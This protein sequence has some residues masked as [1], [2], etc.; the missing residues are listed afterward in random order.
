MRLRPRRIP[1]GYQEWRRLLF[2]HWPVAPEV[3]RPLVPARLSLDLYDGI[4]YISLIPFWIQA[5]RPIGAPRALG[6]SFL[7]TNA[8]TYVHRDGREPGVYFFSLDS[9]SLASVVG[10]RLSVGLP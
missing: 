4:A 10:A 3:V 7:E 8:R 2:L 1:A 6:L 9:T 5:A